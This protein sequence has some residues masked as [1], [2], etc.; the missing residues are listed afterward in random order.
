MNQRVSQVDMVKAHILNLMEEM[1]EDLKKD[2]KV[3][4]DQKWREEAGNLKNWV[5]RIVINQ[6]DAVNRRM[7]TWVES[8]VLKMFESFAVP[9]SIGGVKNDEGTEDPEFASYADF[10]KFT[11]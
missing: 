1:K 8:Q 11:R 2:N 6:V 3:V 4:M 5:E 7:T 9:G 10:V